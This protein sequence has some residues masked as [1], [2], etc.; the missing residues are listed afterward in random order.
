MFTWIK[1]TL[2]VHVNAEKL[3][4]CYKIQYLKKKKKKWNIMVGIN[5][6]FEN[7]LVIKNMV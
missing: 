2:I 6:Y 3:V 5:N 4:V 1:L 7:T